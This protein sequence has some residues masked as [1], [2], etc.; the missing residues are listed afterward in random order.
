VRAE[1]R[2]SWLAVA[3]G[4]ALCASI[5]AVGAD[6]R[7]LAAL[8]GLILEAGRVPSAIPYAAAPSHDWINV[9][10]LGELIFHWLEVLGGDRA[11]I[12]AQAIAV[13][14]MLSLV[15]RDMRAAGASDGARAIVLVAIPVAAVASLF[16][17]RAQ[18]FS[19][20]LFAL[21][22]A[23]LRAEA[24]R[25]SSRIWLL[26]PL[27]ALW[28][29]LHGA[30]LT[31]LA[32][33]SVYLVVERARHDLRT[34][35]EV[36]VAAWVALF[37]TP[38]LGHTWQ[39]YFGVLHS[40][41]AVSGI[42]MWAPLSLTRPLDALFVAIALPLL[43]LAVRSQ[44]KTWELGCI[45]LLIAASVH[46]SRSEV[47]LELFI[48]T[49]ASCGF[50]LRGRT[51]TRGSLAAVAF[52]VPL[53]VFVTGLARTPVQTVAGAGLR[54]EASRL[55]AGQPILADAENAEQLAL[56]KR[57]VWIANPIDAFPRADQRAYLSWL[58]G[59]AGGDSTLRTHD[60][61]LVQ[62]NGAPQKRLAHNA[63]FRE[64]ARDKVAVLY[65]RAS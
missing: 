33:A 14:A 49:P 16:V 39:Y 30:V 7:W 36:L 17:V 24:R 21:T 50:A 26:V 27:V 59:Q 47:W 19:L 18:L 8:G 56:D 44:P 46:A 40:E 58:E 13:A 53:V 43:W 64:V 22:M 2:L 38:A 10:V 23:L 32:L 52:V 29:N 34:A 42:G 4:S 62:L 54:A 11:L 1:S 3:A 61:V 12:A 65:R 63:S 25:P 41:P 20:P 9:P 55:A 35:V 48:A 5:A 15:A 51:I 28:S 45:V 31:G 37:A 57:R 60:V 6:A